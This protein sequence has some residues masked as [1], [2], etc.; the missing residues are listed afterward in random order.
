MWL[1]G[2]HSNVTW[3]SKIPQECVQ[4]AVKYPVM[5]HGMV[6]ELDLLGEV[7]KFGARGEL[8]LIRSKS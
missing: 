2:I 6:C 3:N 1:R 8:F 7:S 5:L 4:V